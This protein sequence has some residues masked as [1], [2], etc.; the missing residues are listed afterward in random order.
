M[1]L[2]VVRIGL[3]VLVAVLAAV[4]A[5][6]LLR[7]GVAATSSLDADVSVECTAA[8]GVDDA[9]CLAWGDGILAQGS[10]STTFEAEDVVRLRLDRELLGFGGS[11]T[12]EWFLGRYPDE[13]VWSERL[14]CDEG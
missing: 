2:A 6:L 3:I 4:A 1:M 13:V 7:P 11:C 5:V 9:S 12:A 8:T 10:P 14:A